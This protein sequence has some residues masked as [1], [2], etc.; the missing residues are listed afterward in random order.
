MLIKASLT[1]RLSFPFAGDSFCLP[2]TIRSGDAEV[3]G[4]YA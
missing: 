2:H 1:P 3:Q 4:V